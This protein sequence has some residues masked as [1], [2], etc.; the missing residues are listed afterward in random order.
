[1]NIKILFNNIKECFNYFLHKN[2]YSYFLSFTNDD[3]I[4]LIQ[5]YIQDGY[6]KKISFYNL[7]RL[8]FPATSLS[9]SLWYTILVCL[10]FDFNRLKCIYKK[11]I[12]LN[13]NLTL[14]DIQHYDMLIFILTFLKRENKLNTDILYQTKI[15]NDMTYYQ[16]IKY[17]LY[18]LQNPK[19]LEYYLSCFIFNFYNYIIHYFCKYNIKLLLESGIFTYYTYIYKYDIFQDFNEH[20]IIK[21]YKATMKLLQRLIEKNHIINDQIIISYYRINQYTQ[22]KI[23]KHYITCIIDNIEYIQQDNIIKSI[24]RFFPLTKR[25]KQKIKPYIDK[26]ESYEFLNEIKS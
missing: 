20:N 10:D 21:S 3:W 24:Y 15:K 22:C 14:A 8:F 26:I 17:I 7:C 9:Y 4:K 25:Q 1:M 2:N 6:D 11:L 18:K 13:A 12:K 23:D 5:Q 16:Q 19:L